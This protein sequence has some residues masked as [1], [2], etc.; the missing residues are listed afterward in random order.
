MKSKL[1]KI[2]GAFVIAFA[3]VAVPFAIAAPDSIKALG[4]ALYW[5]A[6]SDGQVVIRS[7]NKLQ[8]TDN[9]RNLRLAA[10]SYSGG[11]ALDF[12]PALATTKTAAL[13]TG[14]TFTYSNLAAGRMIDVFLT[15]DGSSRT[16]AFP[17][18]TIFVN[19]A[20]TALAANKHAKMTLVS[21][22]AAASG[23]M[24]LYSVEP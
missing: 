23:V 17:S 4:S 21:T 16:L 3:T 24:V 8:G 20:P 6:I 5:G 13:T 10:L 12:D 11:F 19:T 7:S 15:G 2:I 22:T 14:L 9:L 1:L 18:G